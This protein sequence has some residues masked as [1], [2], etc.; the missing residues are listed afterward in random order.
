MEFGNTKFAN[1]GSFIGDV[2][3]T[4]NKKNASVEEFLPISELVVKAWQSHHETQYL[5]RFN[6]FRI[7]GWAAP[8]F[9]TL[10]I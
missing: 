7:R 2:P 3:P 4:M 6:I 9:S 1:D 10:N 5:K 8:N